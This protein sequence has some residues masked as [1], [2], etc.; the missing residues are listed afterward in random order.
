MQKTP[1]GGTY[2]ARGGQ[3]S[4]G[5]SRFTRRRTNAI[6]KVM[7]VACDKM[8]KNQ[9]SKLKE[10]VGHRRDAAHRRIAEYAEALATTKESERE[11]MLMTYREVLVP[12]L[13]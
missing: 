5:T 13:V 9:Y 2:E 8:I 3:A 10:H 4:D 11:A 6:S 12:A 7:C 1:G